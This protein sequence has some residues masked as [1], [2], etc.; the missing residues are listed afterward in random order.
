MV[1]GVPRNATV[2][3]TEALVTYVLGKAE[4]RAAMETNAGFREQ[5]RRYYFQRY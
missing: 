4:F 3:A 1:S 5:L 2:V